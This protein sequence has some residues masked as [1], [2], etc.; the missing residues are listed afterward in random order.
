MTVEC[1]GRG[2]TT[3][4]KVFVRR[5]WLTLPLGGKRRDVS[6]FERFIAVEKSY[7]NDFL[8]FLKTQL[9]TRKKTVSEKAIRRT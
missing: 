6:V 7:I 1:F 3:A 4:V 5:N 8:M 2:N 9:D